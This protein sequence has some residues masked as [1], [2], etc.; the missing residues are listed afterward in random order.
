MTRLSVD[1]GPRLLV[2]NDLDRLGP[3]LRDIFAPNPISGVRTYL[4]GIAE[5]PRSPTR[6]V[7]VGHD[8]ACRN[9]EA[10]V[11][12][13]KASAGVG[14]PVVFCCEPA[15]EDVGRRAVQ[16]GADDYV[17]FPLD[18]VDLE[19]ALGIRVVRR[20]RANWIDDPA[21]APIPSAEELERLADLLPRMATLDSNVL[22]SMAVLIAT[23]LGAQDAA[24][25]VN[26]RIGAAGKLETGRDRA[27]LVEPL[28]LAGR[29]IGQIRVGSSNSGSYSAEDMTKLRHYAVLLGRLLE[30][31][32]RSARWRRLAYT[33]DLTG[34]PNRRRLMR[35]I[36]EK[37]KWAAKEKA[38]VTLLVFDIDDFKLYND[39]YGHNAGDDILSDVGR[40]FVR[41]CR[42]HDMVARYGGDEFV[43][44][45]WDPQGPRTVGSQHPEHVIDVIQRFRKA[46]REHTF[47]RLSAE[48]QGCLT[49]SGGIAHYPGQASGA[50][51]LIEAADKAL[52]LAKEAGKN[53]FWIVG[54]GH[55]TDGS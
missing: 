12:A 4:S 2:V 45:F 11:A 21:V 33:D 16:H 29:R 8:P 9:P 40:L 25:S 10:A 20:T 37:I 47:A 17:V 30:F 23:A 31:G 46:L 34:L 54:D 39:K 26:G 52:L 18:P 24:V 41:C 5:V 48:A 7:L 51:A 36:D 44:V 1:I 27:I 49:I 14:V 35:F 55:S 42:Q 22:E 53:R 50:S 28:H 19:R 15:Y 3:I 13:I 32:R 38:T 43:V 6:A